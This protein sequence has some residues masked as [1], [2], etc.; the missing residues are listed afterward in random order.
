MALRPSGSKLRK[1]LGVTRPKRRSFATAAL[2]GPIDNTE[3]T[4]MVLKTRDMRKAAVQRIRS[5]G[6]IGLLADI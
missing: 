1:V 4:G 2:Q 5:I 3:P 6:Y